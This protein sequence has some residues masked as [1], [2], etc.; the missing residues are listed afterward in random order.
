LEEAFDSKRAEEETAQTDVANP[1]RKQAV[2]S[3]AYVSSGSNK[4]HRTA[5]WTVTAH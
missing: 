5:A 3:S 2:I 4:K 1:E